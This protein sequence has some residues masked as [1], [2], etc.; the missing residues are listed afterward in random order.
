MHPLRLLILAIL[1]YI[2]YRLLVGGLKKKV[3]STFRQGEELPVHD[4]LVEDPICHTYVAKGQAVTL[5]DGD[6]TLYFCS[7]K[8]RNTYESQ[9]GEQK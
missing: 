9:K 7:E 5:K 1:L 2:L 3:A 6:K 8:C 4:V